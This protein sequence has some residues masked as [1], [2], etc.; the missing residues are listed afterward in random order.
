MPKVLEVIGGLTDRIRVLSL[1]QNRDD[2]DHEDEVDPF[3]NNAGDPLH[4]HLVA[5]PS[6]TQDSRCT[7]GSGSSECRWD[8]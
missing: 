6:H 3:N 2:L 1:K 4:D 7:L 5:N 8:S